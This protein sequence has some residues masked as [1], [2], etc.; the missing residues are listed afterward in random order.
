MSLL[1]LGLRFFLPALSAGVAVT[2]GCSAADPGAPGGESVGQDDS[3]LLGAVTY[4]ADCNAG[5]KAFLDKVMRYG[6]TAASSSA[7]SQ[8]MQG[9]MTSQV[10]GGIGPYKKCTGDPFYG[11]SLA[12]QLDRVL[13]AARSTVDM[14]LNCTGAIGG[15]ANA[16]AALDTYGH[17][18]PEVLSFGGWLRSVETGIAYPLCV[19]DGPSPCRFAPDPWPWSQAAGIV[20]HEAMHQQGYTHGAN[21]Q[22]DAKPACGYASYADWNFQVNTM[23]Y[24]VGNCIDQV[25]SQSGTAC[26]APL[27][28]GTGLNLVTTYGGKSCAR[29][30]DPHSATVSWTQVATNPYIAKM[31][32]CSDGDGR[33]Y[34]RNKDHSIWVSHD[35]GRTYSYMQ[36]NTYA[37]QMFCANNKLWI[38]NHD[39]S[40]WRNDGTDTAVQWTYIGRPAGAKQVTGTTGTALFVPYPVLYA[41]NDDNTM[42]KSLTGA[43]GSWTYVS[44]DAAA[45]RITA[46]GGMLEARPFALN[47][48]KLLWLNAGDGCGGYWHPIGVQTG[49]VDVVAATSTSLYKLNSDSTLW[50]GT[51]N[52]SDLL[53]TVAM[54]KARHCDGSTLVP[55]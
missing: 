33:F 22:A 31:A 34:V 40:L 52:S 48:D 21:N 18:A 2:A 26:G 28:N 42:Y 39:R 32:A 15:G 14:T 10:Y 19:K 7:F 35:S 50:K 16:S 25:I 12:V 17:L 54:G 43:D 30:E 27:E 36:T 55:N 24:I 38:V 13:K 20:W 6:R 5:D 49:A 44:T 9:A 4:G 41:L 11:D 29:V 8:C 53:T 1:K 47:Y 37:D 3:S 23:P 45:D 46:G 51:V